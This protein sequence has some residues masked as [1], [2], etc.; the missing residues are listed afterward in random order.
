MA[1]FAGEGDVGIAGGAGER[2]GVRAA[3]AGSLGKGEAWRAGETGRGDVVGI[4]EDCA[5]LAV[6]GALSYG[7][8]EQDVAVDCLKTDQVAEIIDVAGLAAGG[9]GDDAAFSRHCQ[10]FGGVSDGDGLAGSIPSE[11]APVAGEAAQ[12][13]AF[14]AVGV[15]AGQAERS[16]GVES[17]GAFRAAA[18]GAG[19][20]VLVEAVDA[21][22]A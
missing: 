17:E 9:A 12:R 1:Y 3:A 18:A 16:T 22:A 14:L 19:Q 2:V 5:G 4:Q 20:A 6:D 11:V 8:T 13:V 7:S 21:G 10:G 15:G